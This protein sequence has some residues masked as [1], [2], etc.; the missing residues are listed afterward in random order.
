MRT[1]TG[2]LD[3]AQL[4]LHRNPIARM[5]LRDMRLTF[6]S[7]KTIT[8]PWGYTDPMSLD[9]QGYCL[10]DAIVTAAG[11]ILRAWKDSTS[12]LRVNRVT[13]PTSTTQWQTWST[14]VT[15]DGGIGN[16]GLHQVAGGTIYLFYTRATILAYRTSADDGATW[17][18]ESSAG[19][20]LS[21]L[22]SPTVAPVSENE[23]YVAGLITA[24]GVSPYLKVLRFVNSGGWTNSFMPWTVHGDS[25]TPLV[26][27]GHSTTTFFDAFSL[28]GKTFVLYCQGSRGKTW[29]TQ[30]STGTANEYRGLWGNP[31]LLI[32]DES[33]FFKPYRTRSGSRVCLQR[34]WARSRKMST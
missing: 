15:T 10:G 1:V 34:R 31:R 33:A 17:S 29:I 23:V 21:D 3:A 25:T 4:S 30:V 11:T 28:G 9:S 7:Y 27:P 26:S 12:A 14:V 16:P 5:T 2:T 8:N 20:S 6:A 19:G 18:A 13:D 24:G 22:E 32:P